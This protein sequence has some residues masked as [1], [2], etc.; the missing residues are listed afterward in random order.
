MKWFILTLAL[1]LGTSSSQAAVPEVITQHRFEM[2]SEG[3]W[4][5]YTNDQ[6]E[7]AAMC[8]EPLNKNIIGCSVWPTQDVEVYPAKNCLISIYTQ[9][10]ESVPSILAHELR[11]CYQGSW[12]KE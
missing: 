4:I 11:H 9:A 12:H 3:Y 2:T 7:V 10:T 1:F 6:S 8:G 5:I